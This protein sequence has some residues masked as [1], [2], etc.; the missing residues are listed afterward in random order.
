MS[1]GESFIE[2]DARQGR[3]SGHMFVMAKPL[4][5]LQVGWFPKNQPWHELILKMEDETAT[6]LG[7]PC[8][9]SKGRS[10]NSVDFR[11]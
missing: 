10:I 5:D 8:L 11:K 6:N 2:T 1:K 4:D 9:L 3:Q 7:R